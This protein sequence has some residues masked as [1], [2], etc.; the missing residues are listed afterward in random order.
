M[1]PL[2]ACLEHGNVDVAKCLLEAGADKNRATKDGW[3][4]LHICSENG[5]ADVV[6]CLLEAGADKDRPFGKNG[7]A[8]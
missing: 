6:K 2:S 7:W 5:H 3:T 8:A 1:T 4:A